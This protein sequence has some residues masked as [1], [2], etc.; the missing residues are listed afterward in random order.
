MRNN[1]SIRESTQADIA[2]IEAIYPEAFPHEDLLPLVGELLTDA[3]D[4]LSVVATVDERVVSHLIFT[5]CR[6]AEADTNVALLGPLAVVPEWQ[7]KGVG[8]ALVRSGL[9][10]IEKGGTDIV[11]VLGDPNYYQRFGFVTESWIKPPYA[12]PAEWASGWQAKRLRES[13]AMVSAQLAV[14]AQWRKPEL[15]TPPDA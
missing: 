11:L 6:L 15:W 4:A 13:I 2:A 1:L 8:S 3:V 10:R 5:H 14:P 9:Q 7:Q 12:L